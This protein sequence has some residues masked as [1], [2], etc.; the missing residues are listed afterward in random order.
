MGLAMQDYLPAPFVL[1]APIVTVPMFT[2]V[3]LSSSIAVFI[4]ILTCSP[5]LLFI[6]VPF[7]S[8][9]FIKINIKLRTYVL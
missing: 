4:C 8:S 9:V 5:I 3:H 6:R 1:F 2:Y 7:S